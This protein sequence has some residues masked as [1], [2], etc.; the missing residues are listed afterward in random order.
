MHNMGIFQTML[1]RVKGKK[2]E[3]KPRKR[4]ADINLPDESAGTPVGMLLPSEKSKDS[5]KQTYRDSKKKGWR[6]GEKEPPEGRWPDIIFGGDPDDP[7]WYEHN[8]RVAGLFPDK[9]KK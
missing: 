6:A 1:E 5:L 7:R 2:E 3:P 9:K 8:K 4:M